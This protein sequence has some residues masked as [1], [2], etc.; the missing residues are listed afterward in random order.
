MQRCGAD[1]RQ[2]ISG[3]QPT[4]SEVRFFTLCSGW[5]IREPEGYLDEYS[6][7]EPS[8]PEFGG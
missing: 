4:T 3:A 2:K 7:F 8:A 6:G 5:L 1:I